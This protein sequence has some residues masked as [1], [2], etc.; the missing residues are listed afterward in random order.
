MS[1][2]VLS[3]AV[4]KHI[5]DRTVIKFANI[6]FETGLWLTPQMIKK[7]LLENGKINIFY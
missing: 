4:V 6:D 3:T 1:E 7:K 5:D 2:L